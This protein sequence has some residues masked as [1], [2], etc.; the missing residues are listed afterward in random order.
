MN[1]WMDGCLDE[2]MNEQMDEWM[3]SIIWKTRHHRGFKEAETL[4]SFW[5]S[6]KLPHLEIHFCSSLE[7]SYEDQNM[8][9]LHHYNLKQIELSPP[10]KD[11]TRKTWHLLV[12]NYV[13]LGLSSFFFRFSF[14]ISTKECSF[15]FW[16]YQKSYLCGWGGQISFSVK[17][18]GHLSFCTLKTVWGSQLPQ[19]TTPFPQETEILRLY[20][21]ETNCFVSI[22]GVK[23]N[24]FLVTET[25][26]VDTKET[27]LNFLDKATSSPKFYFPFSWKQTVTEDSDSR[28][29][30]SR[31]S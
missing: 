6:G 19:Y 5:I 25:G 3:R 17:E 1:R 29:A 12:M 15:H 30:L 2:W 22:R 14:F 10:P 26:N 11:D 31:W 20:R 7:D 27:G 16:F 13:S 8:F 23:G 18:T 21:P 9:A 4:C 28:R 24:S